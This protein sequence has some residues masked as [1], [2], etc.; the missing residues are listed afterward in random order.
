MSRDA[1]LANIRG[2]LGV[3]A[4]DALRRSTVEARL[5]APPTHLQPGRTRGTETELLDRF[6]GFLQAQA[7]HVIRAVGPAAVPQAIAAFLSAQR[8]PPRLR[9]G[10]DPY[11]A[12]LPWDTAPELERVLGAAQATDTTSLSRAFAGI[13]ETGT[14]LLTSGPENPVTLN[15]LPDTH[16]VVLEEQDVVGP[17]EAAF[18]KVRASYGA[19]KMPRTLNFVSGAS[20]TADIGGKIVIGAHGPR[21][22]AVVLVGTRPQGGLTSGPHSS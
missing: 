2:A 3:N 16:I 14:L 21:Q 19:G 20:R 15:Y 22:L 8:L 12:R 17:Y 4:G 1:I 9:C 10:A 5:A 13:A 18:A 11:L 6:V 7:A